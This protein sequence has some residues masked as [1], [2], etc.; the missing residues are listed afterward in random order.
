MNKLL[1]RL[2][3]ALSVALVSKAE[4]IG[5]YKNATVSRVEPDGIV[6]VHGAGI[7]K[8]PFAELSEELRK[9]YGY[10]AAKA[11]GYAAE[12]SAR[13]YQ[14]ESAA[15]QARSTA[16]NAKIREYTAKERLDNAAAALAQVAIAAKVEPF[17]FG[18]RKTSAK[19]TPTGGKMFIGVIDEPMKEGFAAGDVTR[20]VLYRIGHTDDEQR[21]PLFTS[22]MEKAMKVLRIDARDVN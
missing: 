14:A 3:T 22:K 2:I 11:A 8:V 16:A 20:T 13:Q 17:L 10:D 12:Q 15:S 9:K 7:V 21:L 18:E 4:D 5:G 19:I 6:V 1:I